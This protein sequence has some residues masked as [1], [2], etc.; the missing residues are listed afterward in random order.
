[1]IEF[2][3]DAASDKSTKLIIKGTTET[4]M[5]ESMLFIRTMYNAIGED[6]KEAAEFFKKF[7]TDNIEAAFISAEEMAERTKKIL[8]EKKNVINNLH[9]LLD[10][11]KDEI[12]KTEQEMN[13]DENEES[14]LPPFESFEDW[15]HDR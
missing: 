11:L 13:E 9:S 4:L 6:N 1:M 5:A 12:N 8:E 14:G 10:E 15:L 2:N 3:T 7:V